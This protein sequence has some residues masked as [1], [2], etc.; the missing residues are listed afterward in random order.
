[1]QPLKDA[2][3]E[4]QWMQLNT[5]VAAEAEARKQAEQAAEQ[6]RQLA[7]AQ[8][9]EQ[10]AAEQAEAERQSKLTKVI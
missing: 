10:L 9:A 5:D 1:M 3:S 7:E 6:Q 2:M 8:A 4:G